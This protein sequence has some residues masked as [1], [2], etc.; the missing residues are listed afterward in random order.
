MGIRLIPE[1][2]KNLD[3]ESHTRTE[4]Y[5]GQSSGTLVFIGLVR[6]F[7]EKPNE[8]CDGSPSTYLMPFGTYWIRYNIA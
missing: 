8:M 4:A 3:R 7:Q 1:R 6:S 2:D 5:L